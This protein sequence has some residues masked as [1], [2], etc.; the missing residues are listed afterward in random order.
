MRHLILIFAAFLCGNAFSQNAR[1]SAQVKTDDKPSLH[2]FS[3]W[4]YI[5]IVS[6]DTSFLY[7]LHTSN[8]DVIQNLKPGSYKIG[9]VSVF[10][11]YLSKK[12]EV[13]SA[14]PAVK[15][16]GLVTYYQKPKPAG[17]LCEK[18]KPGD[19]LFVICSNTANENEKEK[20]AVTKTKNGY[21]AIQ[22][23]GISNE[24]V[25]QMLFKP[26]V[27]NAIIKFET[28]GKKA[29]SPKAETAPVAEVCTIE[30]NRAT[31]VFIVPGKWDG[32]NNLKASLFA[33]EN[34][35]TKK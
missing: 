20:L 27:F 30:L 14:L 25:Q 19:T 1:C 9:I 6:K 29:N 16:N 4:Q 24:I 18:I 13:N 5:K 34:G 12:V 32:F 33:I 10:N 8:P 11:H 26:E 31:E 15:F 17:N 35:P 23:K 22:Y 2:G 21:N 28:E 7:R 3:Y